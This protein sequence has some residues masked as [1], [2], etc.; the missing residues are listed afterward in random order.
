MRGRSCKGKCATGKNGGTQHGTST[1]IKFSVPTPPST[2]FSS[3]GIH[4]M[5]MAGSC[6]KVKYCERRSYYLIYTDI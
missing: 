2:V 4:A 1:G 5:L 3:Y 6:P